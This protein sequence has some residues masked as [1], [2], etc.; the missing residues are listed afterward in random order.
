MLEVTEGTHEIEMAYRSPGLRGG[1]AHRNLRFRGPVCGNPLNL[2]EEKLTTSSVP[3]SQSQL[4]HQLVKK[5]GARPYRLP[6][7]L[8]RSR[9]V[10][11]RKPRARSPANFLARNMQ[12]SPE[13]VK[14]GS[15]SPY[16]TEQP[17]LLGAYLDAIE[18]DALVH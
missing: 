14:G 13:N 12:P 11:P 17:L 3:N 2:Q 6:V 10:I 9:L 16:V 4:A 8:K 5:S 18:H 7:S 15:Q 1:G